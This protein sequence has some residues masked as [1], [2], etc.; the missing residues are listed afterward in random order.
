MLKILR[1]PRIA[2]PLSMILLFSLL[3][4]ADGC[5]Y[6][7]VHRSKEPPHVAVTQLQSIGKLMI[8]HLDDR[9]WQFTGISATEDTVSGF[10]VPLSGHE[11]YK[12]VN[13][14]GVNRYKVNGPTGDRSITNEVHIYTTGFSQSDSNVVA[15]PTKEIERIEI[16]DPAA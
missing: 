6:F 16:Y 15:V 7:R 1:S 2:G 3:I 4:M 9:A 10:I 8:L 5:N 11:R 14:D 13:R 12:T